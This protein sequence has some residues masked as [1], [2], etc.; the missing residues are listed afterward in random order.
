MIPQDVISVVLKN[1]LT[2]K[3]S[4]GYLKKPEY[5]HLKE[6]NKTIYLSSA[7]FK[8]HWSYGLVRSF[9][10]NM[11]EEK[12][13]YF[14]CGLPYQL[15]VKVGILDRNDIED[16]MSESSYNEVTWSMENE[17]LWFGDTGGGF[18]NYETVDATRKIIYPWLPP[19]RNS[20]PIDKKMQIPPKKDGEIRGISADI[21][22]MNTTKRVKNDAT[23]IFITSSSPSTGGRYVTNVQYTTVMEGAHTSDQ[24]LKV[25]RLYEDYDCDYIA[26]DAQGVGM[27]VY[28]ALVRDM[29]DAE[30]GVTYPA[31]SCYNNDEMASRCPK[32]AKKAIW[33]IKAS[34]EFNSNCALLLREG[35]NSNRIRLLINEYE[36]DKVLSNLKGY[37][38]LSAEEKEELKLPYIDTTLLIKEVIN[39]QT[40]AR[41][42]NKIKVKEKSNM[43]KDRYSS[44]S[45]NYWVVSQIESENR[46]KL[47]QK[48]SY[49]IGDLFLYRPPKI[50]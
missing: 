40:E 33:S 23:A 26:L 4:P 8:S 21:A 20:K 42:N 27:G 39:L 3:R 43:R 31:L 36:A 48:M 44:L 25:R 18:F 24:A 32:D 49:D 12:R 41:D 37:N 35:F 45:Y 16:T 50:R 13:K 15:S 6:Q 11:L 17:C 28:D 38:K 46:Y 14:V 1:F 7:Y 10:K 22:L 29:Y 47:R 2:A 5:E 30:L 9:C 34:A 19:T